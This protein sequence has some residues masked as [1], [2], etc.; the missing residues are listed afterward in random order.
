ML[1]ASACL[2]MHVDGRW[3]SSQLIAEGVDEQLSVDRGNTAAGRAITE[4]QRH[5]GDAEDA[6]MH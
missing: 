1:V 2:M 4:C 5:G 6:S 3:F